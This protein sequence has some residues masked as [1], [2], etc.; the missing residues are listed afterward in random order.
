MFNINIKKYI[1][2]LVFLF[3]HS[4][5]FFT[6]AQDFL[7]NQ[8]QEL[9]NGW[10]WA[11]VNDEKEFSP[12][13]TAFF[14]DLTSLFSGKKTGKIFLKNEFYL[15]NN[16]KNENISLY[17]GKINFSDIT[18]LNG[19]QI[20]S[21]GNFP[22]NEFSTWNISRFYQIPENLIEK[23]AKNVLLIEIY[24]NGEGFLQSFP[25]LSTT[26]YA[27]QLALKQNFIN[28]KIHL[29]CAFAMLIIAS[30]FFLFYVR[31]TSEKE[32]LY[33]A[34]FN[35]LSAL[36]LS[37]FYIFE[38]TLFPNEIFSYLNFQKI[39]IKSL[40]FLLFYILGSFS[41]EF[42][43]N[44]SNKIIE[45]MRILFTILPILV[46]L[47][48]PNYIILTQVYKY[49]ILL[50]IFQLLYIFYQLIF[51]ILRKERNANYLLLAFL[52]IILVAIADLAIHQVF[53]KA[54]FAYFSIFGWIL[55][56]ASLL[57]MLIF[58]FVEEQKHTE[59]INSLFENMAHERSVELNRANQILEETNGEFSVLNMDYSEDLALALTVQGLLFFPTLKKAKNVKNWQVAK[60]FIKG[61]KE[62][63]SFFDFYTKKSEEKTEKGETKA[64]KTE[65]GENAEEILNGLCLFDINARHVP[66]V[67]LGILV[68]KLTKIQFFAGFKKPLGQTMEC[69][70]AQVLQVLSQEQNSV[71]GIILRINDER[72]EYVNAG[73]AALLCRKANGNILTANLSDKNIE[74]TALGL[75]G[76]D[77]QYSA[78][79]FGM[80]AGDCVLLYSKSL[81]GLRNLKGEEFGVEYLKTI[82]ENATGESAA[83]K[84]NYILAQF[85]LQTQIENNS[86]FAQQEKD[87]AI[88]ILQRQ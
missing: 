30:S 38:L 6:F 21:T 69:L 82:F 12:I 3:F 16:L 28:C 79:A 49:L 32:N 20:G 18:Y 14:S 15:D 43:Q 73:H 77:E 19:K 61:N 55:V 63:S 40:P 53:K 66:S 74:G 36:H 57:F 11:F 25:F 88:I 78:L 87:L 26:K 81:L 59:Q 85:N 9:K 31:R 34:I 1:T 72:I 64:A 86:T 45:K 33:F 76:L 24:T 7:N 44:S 67:L 52:P 71:S 5:Q 41:K 50:I 29:L 68:K 22:P 2:I 8:A 42:L 60:A 62:G 80:N 58:R 4:F 51:A 83:E 37:Q 70:N 10:L 13:D 46:I 35:L 56:S 54:E 17:L 48:L 27:K 39:I 23:N 47:F 65:N 84:L 75:S